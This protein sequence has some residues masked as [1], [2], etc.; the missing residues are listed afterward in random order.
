MGGISP[1]ELAL[2]VSRAGGVGTI[3]VLPGTLVEDLIEQLDAMVAEL[4][5]VLAVN[6]LDP[7]PST[8]RQSRPLRPG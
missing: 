4:T 3:T 2:A 7:T 6:F 8:R 1:P 5:G